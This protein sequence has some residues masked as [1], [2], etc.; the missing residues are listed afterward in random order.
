MSRR[1]ARLSDVLRPGQRVFVGAMA[2][3]SALLAEELRADP[4]RAAGVEFVAVQFPGIDRLDYLASHPD[5]RLSAYFM[6][7]SVR[8]GLQAGRARLF[9]ADYP[10]IVH[11]LTEGPAADVAVAQ[12]SLPDDQ[13][14]CSAGLCSD[15]LPLAWPRARQRVA[16]LNPR[17][18]RTAGRFRVHLDELDGW[19][20]ADRPLLTYQDPEP[21][22]T[23]L[24]IA[25]Q[26]AQLVR[27]GDTVQCGIGTIPLA[28]GGA[29]R[30]HRRLKLHTGMVTRS[31]R[32][33]W[34]AG[35]LDEDARIT[36]GMALGDEAF[37]DFVRTC[38]QLWFD[39][40][41]HTHDPVALSRVQGFVA[42]N[43]AIEV[44]L[45]GQVNAER[46]NG[47]LPSGP[48]GLPVFA[49][50][51]LRAPQGRLLI[52]LRATAGK[53]QT[54][55][56]VPCLDAQGLCTLPRHAAD[57][58]ITEHGV[59]RLRGL[60]LAQRAHALIGIAAP[61]HRDALERAWHSLQAGL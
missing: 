44:D 22:E 12:L 11:H 13:G 32:S 42:I 29:L 8:Q 31:L 30:H 5:A 25:R 9:S 6:S 33:L 4:Q 48:G 18:P 58:V 39:D 43:S 50:A 49:Q 17:M 14:W 37:H 27:D 34:L 16:H 28:L 36:T 40:V 55:R 46:M 54:S 3:E 21:G 19:V 41:A 45:F 60:D 24:A 38:P 57:T 10:G 20:E 59:A 51:A 56:I 47:Q 52:C 2:G 61:E 15:F 1:L 35:A 53:R 23:D 26:A 7:P